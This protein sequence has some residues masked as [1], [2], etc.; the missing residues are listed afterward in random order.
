[1][2]RK[3]IIIALFFVLISF[4]FVFIGFNKTEGQSQQGQQNVQVDPQQQFLESIL[5]SKQKKQQ[6]QQQSEQQQSTEQAS[7]AQNEAAK[8]IENTIKV[9]Y[10]LSIVTLPL[11]W[12]FL[13]L[14]IISILKWLKYR[15]KRVI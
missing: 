10:F 2:K 7:A 8:S 13:V 12:T 15:Q 5:K 4:S 1:M 9:V 14:G 6:Q 11:L 3:L